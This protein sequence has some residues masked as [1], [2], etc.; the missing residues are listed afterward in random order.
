MDEAKG[1]VASAAKGV[2]SVAL[3]I[4][5][6]MMWI[7][8]FIFVL[9]IALIVWMIASSKSVD[10][11]LPTEVV[12]GEA[13]L[14][15]DDLRRKRDEKINLIKCNAQ[16]CSDGTMHLLPALRLKN[17]DKT[18]NVLFMKRG[19]ALQL[20]ARAGKY[21]LRIEIDSKGASL[22]SRPRLRVGGPSSAVLGDQLDASSAS[23]N[24]I[25]VPVEITN[26]YLRIE[27]ASE[28]S[29]PAW[30]VAAIPRSATNIPPSAKLLIAAQIAEAGAIEA[31][32]DASGEVQYYL[33]KDG[34]VPD[35]ACGQRKTI[36]AP[37][38]PTRIR[39]IRLTPIP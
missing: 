31:C 36:P 18:G 8:I 35:S 32:P 25:E 3:T 39:S 4:W 24:V 22:Q 19:E 20:T 15:E 34:V 30:V 37:D 17:D 1:A 5:K 2:F 29:R 14:L 6:I 11:T 33:F 16:Y 9:I 26:A 23:P 28:E 7:G 21:M 38:F 10:P 27:E 13:Q 12:F